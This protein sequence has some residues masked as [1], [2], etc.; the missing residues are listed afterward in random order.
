MKAED[1]TIFEYRKEKEL[2]NIDAVLHERLHGKFEKFSVRTAASGYVDLSI[3]RPENAGETEILPA[4]FSF[5]GGGFV[6]G[7]YE[8]DGPYCQLL[9]D[10]SGCAVV[11]VDY[12]LA[13]EFKF[14]KPIYSSYEAVAAVV[15][16]AAAYRIDPARVMVCGHS[17]GGAIAAALCLLDRDRREIGIRGQIIDYAPLRQSLSPEDR[18][19]LDPA[20]AI[21]P[22]RMVQY[23]NWYFEDLADMDHP[24]ASPANAELH[25]L[26][27]AL[28]I[29]AE[30]DS[31]AAEEKEFADKASRAGT[32]V[33]YM[34]FEGCQHGFT[35]KELKEYMP[36]QAD[37]AWTAMGAFIREKMQPDAAAPI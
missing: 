4:V 19:A 31:L 37:R 2:K 6:L 7:Y 12:C 36:A 27:P 10:R 22:S 34:L 3:Y 33:R 30:Y 23:I 1:L 29:S 9:A 17:A 21:K 14:P 25:D 20:K 26:P 8:A 13:P 11:N 16:N 15:R 5:H 24:L 35:H 18:R 28:V 32:Q